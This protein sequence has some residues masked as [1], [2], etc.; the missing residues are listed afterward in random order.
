[1]LELQIHQRHFTECRSD[2]NTEPR[3]FYI[4]LRLIYYTR[5]VYK[6]LSECYNML[7]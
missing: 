4:I 2:T 7:L 5:T 6:Y 1:M 3:V